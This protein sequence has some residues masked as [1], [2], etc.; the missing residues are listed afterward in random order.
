MRN[1]IKN[2]CYYG[3]QKMTEKIQ[4]KLYKVTKTIIT[5]IIT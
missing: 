2:Y 1:Y 3:H 5:K 4:K